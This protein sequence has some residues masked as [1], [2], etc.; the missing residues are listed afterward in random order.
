MPRKSRLQSLCSQVHQPYGNITFSRP[1][2]MIPLDKTQVS[3]KVSEMEDLWTLPTALTM[4]LVL[5]RVIDAIQLCLLM[6]NW[7][8]VHKSRHNRCR[9][10]SLQA[11]VP[12]LM[13]SK[14]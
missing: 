9:G 10:S 8:W 5:D 14:S 11:F 12:C 2:T 13:Q 1:V 3:I 7:K 4:L 6:G